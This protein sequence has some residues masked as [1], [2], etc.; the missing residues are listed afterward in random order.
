M[1]DKK[2]KEEAIQ[3]LDYANREPWPDPIVLEEDVFAP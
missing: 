1:I 2:K 3:A